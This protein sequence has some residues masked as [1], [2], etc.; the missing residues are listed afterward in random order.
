[1]LPLRI[2]K[3]DADTEGLYLQLQKLQDDELQA[4]DRAWVQSHATQVARIKASIREDGERSPA[5]REYN[6]LIHQQAQLRAELIRHQRR[7]MDEFLSGR[8]KA[9]EMQEGGT[10]SQSGPVFGHASTARASTA[11]KSKK[12]QSMLFTGSR[13]KFSE[14]NAPRGRLPSQT[15]PRTDRE[16]DGLDIGN[17]QKVLNRRAYRHGTK[18]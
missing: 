13:A 14:S 8:Q 11:D 1:M 18:V 15:S 3:F 2:S 7:A 12:T 10:L 9:R 6:N 4:W 17:V 16:D 5:N